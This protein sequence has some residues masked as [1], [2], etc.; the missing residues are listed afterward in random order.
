MHG[1]VNNRQGACSLTNSG[2][3]TCGERTNSRTIIIIVVNN[4]QMLDFSW[5]SSDGFGAL[6]AL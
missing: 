3:I 5:L 6:K 2:P 4:N 1:I